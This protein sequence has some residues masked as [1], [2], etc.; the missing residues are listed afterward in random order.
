M[1]RITDVA[2]RPLATSRLL[3]L[4]ATWR[5]YL[6]KILLAKRREAMMR[7]QLDG[8]PAAFWIR[9]RGSDLDVVLQIFFAR[10]Y[11]LSWCMPYKLHLQTLCDRIIE[12][13]NTPLIIDAGA[14]IGAS[15]LWFALNFPDCRIFAVEPDH[16]NFAVLEKNVGAYPNITLF[17]AG[18]WDR[19]ANLSIVSE[20]DNS[21]G[22]R[23]EEQAGDKRVVPS[24][25][26]PD[27][28]AKD[29]RIRPIIVKIDIEGAETALLRSNTDWVDDIPLLIFEPHDNLWHWLGTWQG[30]GHAFFSALARRKHEYLFRGENVFA[31]LHPDP[32]EHYEG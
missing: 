31:F 3:G 13:G 2:R 22:R 25:T 21:W 4:S 19:P 16:G 9:P 7:I 28:L 26:I 17:N 18:L 11:D 6:E 14:N 32:G 5:I 12:D 20:S 30:T 24:V 29:D 10:D 8:S 15:T 27:L 23:I 1:G